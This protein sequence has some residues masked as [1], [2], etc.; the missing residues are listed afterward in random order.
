MEFLYGDSTSS[1]LA[2]D[3]VDL[4]R[5]A[6]DSCVA[7]LQA[8]QRM[9]V[10]IAHRRHLEARAEKDVVRLREL[11]ATVTRSIS[12][13]IEG[14]TPDAPVAR[15]G[16]VIARAV[17]SAVASSEGDVQASLKAE[18]QRI[19]DSAAKE[20]AR[21]VKAVEQL[22]LAHDLPGSEREVRIETRKEGG[23]SAR[24]HATTPY[25]VTSALD[26]EIAAGNRFAQVVRVGDLAEALEI[27]VPKTGGWLRKE[28]RLTTER[29]GRL[30]VTS[31]RVG[32]MYQV[33]L[34]GEGIEEGYD[35]SCVPRSA[36][37]HAIRVAPD[38][39]SPVDFELNETDSK[40]VV[41]FLEKLAAA[42]LELA[43]NR[44]ALAQ[45]QLD[46]ES[47][48]QQRQPSLLVQRLIEVMAP[49]VREIAARSGSEQ[50][51]VIRRL[52]GDGRREERYVRRSELLEKLEPLPAPARALFA[53]LGLGDVPGQ[54]APAVEEVS[55]E[56]SGGYIMEVE[57][58][59][60]KSTEPAKPPPRPPS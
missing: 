49:T 30:I 58:V 10:G 51:L 41:A 44:K 33:S 39:P 1:P 43:P 16:D 19:E 3:Y 60:A 20:R 7:L 13:V 59:P 12:L 15:C 53:P 25:G 42:A 27:Q 35:F 45:V 36:R 48:E 24:L 32:R 31:C 26:L 28:S 23:H 55:V 47:L 54:P 21:C 40:A 29:L 8:E 4:L 5:K 14:A 11:E 18:F 50:E 46:G 56:I 34:R 52:L 37:V 57:G 9:N 6:I 17:S 38:L 2:T 22:L